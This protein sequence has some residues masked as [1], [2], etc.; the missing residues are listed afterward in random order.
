MS[1]PA[2]HAGL[3]GD[4]KALGLW[5]LANVLMTVF[6]RDDGFHVF[7]LQAS[8]SAMPLAQRL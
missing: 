2:I 3:L 4:S 7:G 8:L 5:N 6:G 1:R